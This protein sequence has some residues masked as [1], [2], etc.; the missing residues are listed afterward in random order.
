VPGL[1][2]LFLPISWHISP[3]DA[4]SPRGGMP[5]VV[6]LLALPFF[7]AVPMAAWRVRALW[8]RPVGRGESMAMLAV[9]FTAILGF[10]W[11][12]YLLLANAVSGHREVP[13][14]L[15][16]SW[17]LI[18]PSSMLL[19]RAWRSPRDLPV[20]AEQFLCG[21]Y[22][23]GAAVWVVAACYEGEFSYVEPG[24]WMAAVACVCDAA[25]I[26]L[27]QVKGRA[28]TGDAAM[29]IARA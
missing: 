26:A 2:A 8:R 18:L 9:A 21:S 1:V 4:V 15:G 22:L 20:A 25:L 3:I 5:L 14:V 29:G 12:S 6:W 27:L 19:A 10:A 13:V 7:V 11:A 28:E 24:T 16:L 17:A 23:P